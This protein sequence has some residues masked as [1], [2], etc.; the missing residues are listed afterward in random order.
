MIKVLYQSKSVRMNL[1]H[2]LN[3]Y[4]FLVLCN[5]PT[6]IQMNVEVSLILIPPKPEDLSAAPDAH[7]MRPNHIVVFFHV[8]Q[9]LAVG[10]SRA[11]FWCS[12]DGVC[13][14]NVHL[15][16]CV[17]VS[18]APTSTK[19]TN[20]PSQAGHASQPSAMTESRRGT[21]SRSSKANGADAEQ[22]ALKK[23]QSANR[24]WQITLIA[25]P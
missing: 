24:V 18:T 1:Q 19:I 2:L 22:L 20:Q 17:C 12:W 23:W 13:E 16:V 7:S 5:H 9:V 14:V 4:H 11:S 15:C 21:W 8:S 10:N 25:M 6:L 3:L